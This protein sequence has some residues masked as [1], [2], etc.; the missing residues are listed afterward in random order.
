MW[1]YI[2]YI[3]QTSRFVIRHRFK[4]HAPIFALRNRIHNTDVR[5][6]ILPIVLFI[7]LQL[8]KVNLYSRQF[9]HI[10]LYLY[11]FSL[12]VSCTFFLLLSK[13]TF[14]VCFEVATDSRRCLTHKLLFVYKAVTDDR[15]WDYLCNFF[16]LL[17]RI[18][19]VVKTEVIKMAILYL[20]T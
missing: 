11:T 16:S 20:C 12:Y 10:L 3:E 14:A 9:S 7:S 5:F 17:Q 4:T 18:M 15:M 8:E 19:G 1:C 2:N 6:T 13:I